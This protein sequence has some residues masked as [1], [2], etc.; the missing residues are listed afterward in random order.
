MYKSDAFNHEMCRPFSDF[1]TSYGSVKKVRST[2]ARFGIFLS[3]DF[4]VY[5][6]VVRG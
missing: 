3:Y 1:F 4:W 2:G 5:R 6:G